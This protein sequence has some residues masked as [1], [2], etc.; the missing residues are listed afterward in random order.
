MKAIITGSTGM[1]G[2]AVLIECLDSEI[3]DSVLLINRQP[4]DVSHPK[5]KEV[6]HPDFTDFSS[7]RE[8]LA[9]Y[10]GCFHCMGVSAVGMSEERFTHITY[11][12]TN[13]LAE[14]LY[15]LNPNMVFNYVSGTGTDSTEKGRVMWARVKGRTENLLLSMGFKDAYAFR[16]GAILPGKGLKSKTPLY[17][18]TDVVMKPLF[19]LLKKMDSVITSPEIGQAM[20][21]TVLHPQELKHLENRDIRRLAKIL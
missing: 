11:T 16:P 6:I 13:A 4:I 17:N 15:D 5:I 8:Q 12:M 10:D 9:G 20:I 2:K 3:I 21:N 19:P 7:I 18:A 14:T 1:V